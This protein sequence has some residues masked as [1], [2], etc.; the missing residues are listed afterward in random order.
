MIRNLA[1]PALVLLAQ[2]ALTLALA[3]LLPGIV[4]KVKALFAGRLGP[5]V[6]QLYYDLAKLMR[7]GAVFSR[8]T[9]GVFL[10]GPAVS[11]AVP[12]TA[13]LLIPMGSATAPVSFA[14]DAVVLAY[15]FGVARFFVV[16][17]A[18]DTGSAF[19]G[20]GAAREV[21]FAV[22]AEPALFMGLATLA[23]LSGEPSM[24]P[25]LTAAGQGWRAASGPLALV[26]TAWVIVF[27]VENCRIPFDDPNTHLELTMIHEVM[28]LDHSGPP[29]AA[30]LYG[31]SLKLWVLGALVVKLCLPLRGAWWIDWPA[32]LGGMAL[33]ACAVGVLE[34]I[35]AR[36]RM[37]RVSQALIAAVVS[38][39]FGFLLLLL[40]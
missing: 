6:L 29:L 28:V 40:A 30:V 32:F 34:S 36:L 11:V 24:A 13:A 15:L 16:L 8:T 21:T 25:M 2:M 10:A 7:K 33:L 39:T 35:M 19:E 27:L 5:P 26:L 38:G 31:A 4:N 37:R 20:M 14:G 22:L 23:R 9:T 18:L 17:A 12:F 1:Q 3:P